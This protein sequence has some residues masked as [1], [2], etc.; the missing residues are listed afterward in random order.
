MRAI[1][2]NFAAFA[3]TATLAG[4]AFAQEPM[5]QPTP[6]PEQ[7]PQQPAA[8]VADTTTRSESTEASSVKGSIVKVDPDLMELTIKTEDDIVQTFRFAESTAVVG[9]DGP[10]TELASKAGSTVKVYFTSTGDTKIATKVE[11]DRGE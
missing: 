4:P 2:S 7:Q 8:P 6:A 9:A 1:T 10:V 3:I 11:F 5:P